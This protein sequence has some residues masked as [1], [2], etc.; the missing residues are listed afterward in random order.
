MEQKAKFIIVGLIGVTV[1]CAFLVIQSLGIKQQLTREKDELK[2][3][4]ISLTAKI[5]YFLSETATSY[6]PVNL[7][8]ILKKFRS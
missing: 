6:S 5:A 1:V 8:W 3:E 4:N 2:S 7:L